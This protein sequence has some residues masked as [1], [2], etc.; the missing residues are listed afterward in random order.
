MIQQEFWQ[1][2]EGRTWLFI[3]G[4]A[5][6]LFLYTLLDFGIEKAVVT[7]FSGLLQ[8][9]L[10][11]MVAAGFSI[12]FGLLDV[13]NFAQGGFFMLGA[14][15]GLTVYISTPLESVPLG[16]AFL[17]SLGVAI[18]TGILLGAL[19]EIVLI[20]PLYERPVFTLLLTFGLSAVI[21]EIVL[22]IPGWGPA[23]KNPPAPP[24]A[25]A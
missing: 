25:R 10:I 6:I 7:G 19:T 8:A 2:R 3:I 5:A 22:I 13:L 15:V 20:R 12:I 16:V 23:A 21:R 1:S 14:Y 17:L 9:M 4:Y 11:F 18:F 24:A